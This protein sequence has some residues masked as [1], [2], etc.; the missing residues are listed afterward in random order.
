MS[1]PTVQRNASE[2]WIA[3]ELPKHEP[4]LCPVT[5]TASPPFG[6]TGLKICAEVGFGVGVNALVDVVD[7]AVELVVG[8]VV[9]V[10]DVVDVVGVEPDPPAATA[11]A[12]PITV[13][14]R[15][16]PAAKARGRALHR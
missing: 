3:I 8:V 9:D 7:V 10:V 16:A 5:E 2:R 4:R 15:T 6:F 12:T 1:L 11:T 14:S 13:T